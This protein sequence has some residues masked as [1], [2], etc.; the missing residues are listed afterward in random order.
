[1]TCKGTVKGGMVVLDDPTVLPDG[2]DVVVES[3]GQ[4]QDE[5]EMDDLRRMLLRHAGKAKNLPPDMA[6]NHDH[7]LHGAPKK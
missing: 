2:T 3:V 1:M 5:K 7:Y 6:L 4:S